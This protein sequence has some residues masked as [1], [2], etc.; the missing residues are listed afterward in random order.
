MHTAARPIELHRAVAADFDPITRTLTLVGYKG[1]RGEERRRDVP[2]SPAAVA[3]FKRMA[4]GKLP[5][6]PL[7]PNEKGRRWIHSEYDD[8]FRDIRDRA[9][10][11]VDVTMYVIRHSIIAE[12][13]VYGIDPLTVSK[14]AG[15]G[16]PMLERNYAKFIR[17]KVA[18]RVAAI[19]VV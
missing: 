5:N 13:L 3:F 2:L 12:W 4:D 9:G 16:L 8:L 19:E 18:D 11:P 15:T 17:S 7:L 14:I 10:L 6:G 1:K